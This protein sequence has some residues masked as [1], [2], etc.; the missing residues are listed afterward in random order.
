MKQMKF[1]LVAL[2]AVVMGMSVTSCMDG[3]ENTIVPVAGIITLK[4]NFIQPEFQVEGGGVTFIANNMVEGLSNAQSGDIVFL[5]A[6]YD[7][8]T[9][10]VDQNTTKI[11]VDVSFAF[12]L[13]TYVSTY[14]T[15]TENANNLSNRSI[16]PLSEYQATPIMY[17]ADW[18]VIPVLYYT[19]KA[20][21]KSQHS[22]TLVYLEDE[23]VKNS[24]LKLHLYHN[25]SEDIEKEKAIN[26]SY[27]YESYKAFRISSLIS[28]FKENNNGQS[29]KSIVV[30]TQ[31]ASGKAIE[32]KEEATGY[33]E[34]EYT[35][36]NYTAK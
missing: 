33:T 36:Q 27:L 10:P 23:E 11:Y 16:M 15:T 2:M 13:N 7:T 24:T 35:V 28:K 17:G 31:E 22:F 34:R 19:E 29:P 6:Q 1:F 21:N 4:S 5:S 18:V 3:E 14:N 26:V 9:Q 12:Q 8:K 30:V 20:E 32:I 25:S